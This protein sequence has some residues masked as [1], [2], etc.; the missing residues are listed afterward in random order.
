MSWL[1]RSRRTGAPGAEMSR[2]DVGAVRT[3][4]EQFVATRRGVEAYVEPATRVTATTVVLIAHDGEFTRRPLPDRQSAFEVA[5]RLGVPVYDVNLT[6]Y[7]QRMRDW[8]SRH[9]ED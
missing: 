4:L 2:S 1:R 5:R 9:R 8:T 7:P 6:G 3:H